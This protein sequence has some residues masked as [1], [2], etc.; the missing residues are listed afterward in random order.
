MISPDDPWLIAKLCY[1][2]ICA[3]GGIPAGQR[4]SGPSCKPAKA[5]SLWQSACRV[6]I[7]LITLDYSILMQAVFSR[8][9][10]LDMLAPTHAKLTG[11]EI[12]L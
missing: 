6:A 12:F 9:S 11:R 4:D 7:W 3:L 10:D 5:D 8:V 2:R 1:V